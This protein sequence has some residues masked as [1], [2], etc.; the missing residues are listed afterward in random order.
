MK[1][2]VFK[3]MGILFAACIGMFALSFSAYAENETVE[4]MASYS[5]SCGDNLTWTLDTNTGELNIYGDGAMDNWTSSAPAPW[6]DYRDQINEIYIDIG[7]TS[8]GDYAFYMCDKVTR[9]GISVFYSQATDFLN[10]I[11]N[12]AFNGCSSLESVYIPAGVTS[13]GTLAFNGCAALTDIIIPRTVTNI[14]IWAYRSCTSLKRA[15]ILGEITAIPSACFQQ[16]SA[17]S[18]VGIPGRVSEIGPSAFAGCDSLQTICFSGSVSDWASIT[19]GNNNDSLSS[20]QLYTDAVYGT[21]GVSAVWIF[22]ST[23]ELNIIGEGE[24]NSYDSLGSPWRE[25]C[26]QISQVTIF[27]GITTIGAGSFQNCT[28]LTTIFIPSSIETI[29][30]HSLIVG[31]AFLHCN[32]MTEIFVDEENPYFCDVD[33][34]LY[35]KDLTELVYYPSGKNNT[36]YSIPEQ[37]ITI[38]EGAFNWSRNLKKVIIPDSVKTIGQWAFFGSA[39]TSVAIPN[40]VSAIAAHGFYGCS[41]MRAMIIPQTVTSLGESACVCCPNLMDVYYDGTLQEW[42]ELLN[43]VQTSGSITT[44]YSGLENVNLFSAEDY[45]ENLTVSITTE[46]VPGGVKVTMSKTGSGTIYYTLDGTTPCTASIP[47]EEPFLLEDAGDIFINAIVIDRSSGTY[48]DA[49]TEYVELKQSAVPEIYEQAGA[50]CMNGPANAVY[51]SLD[52]TQEPTTASDRYLSPVL[53]SETTVVRARVIEAGK[54]ASSVVSYAF[55]VTGSGSTYPDDSYRFGNTGESFGYSSVYRIGEE[56]YSDIF[57]SAAGRFLYEIYKGKWGGSCF[58]MSATSLMFSKGVLSLGDYNNSARTVNELLAPRSRDSELTKLI[59]RYQ[60]AQFLPEMMKERND[61]SSGGNMVISGLSPEAAGDRLLSAI[62]KACNGEEPIILILW[63]N[64]L[65]GSHAVVPY[66]L[67]SGRIYLYD[68]N[69]PNEEN[70]LTYTKNTDGTYS[71]HYEEYSYAVSYNTLSKLLEGLEGLQTGQVSLTADGKEQMLVS[72]NTKSFRILD[73][74]GKEVTNYITVRATEDMEQSAE[75]VLYLD[76]GTYTILNTDSSLESITLSAATE[77]DLKGVTVAD[78]SARIQIGVKYRHLSITVNSEEQTSMIFR[79]GN[80]SG[81]ENEIGITAEYAKIYAST[82]VATMVETTAPNILANG[83]SLALEKSPTDDSIYFGAVGGNL[84][85]TARPAYDNG[86]G[87]RISTD[88][89][90]LLDET[91]TLTA[92]VT[93]AGETAVV[94]AASYDAAGKMT[95]IHSWETQAG[96]MKYPFTIEADT[97]EVKI[98]VLDKTT[99]E[100]LAEA[101]TIR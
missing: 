88:I 64:G 10:A 89:T 94:Y 92:N 68:S 42:Q 74:E 9:F 95:A 55:Y 4:L 39:L 45:N 5:G 56:R 60:V 15:T 18:Y 49:V 85:E 52:L 71:F 101:L 76:A 25:Y 62:Q 59:E 31:G 86:S 57:G 38:R 98:Y 34:V 3:I 36:E 11:G 66:K 77:G 37:T 21:C 30:E 87:V 63:K 12:S 96:K 97:S 1:K 14:G 47:Y 90:G 27:D 28:S 48:G 84:A 44:N 83:T 7:V 65:N 91:F 8:I 70:I 53:L 24:I 58:G 23:G 20:G 6:S 61:I 41:A 72:L 40:G 46:A 69:S 100:P 35:S 22:L 17:L 73:V 79:T 2:Q 75:T 80:G 99:K 13:I 43:S 82:D 50:I 32:E 81:Q 54:A 51:Y 26:D 29:R 16:C 33:G 67:Q 19:I 78:P 93:G